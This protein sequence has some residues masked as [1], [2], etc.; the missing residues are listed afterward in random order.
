MKLFLKRKLEESQAAA[1]TCRTNTPCYV[2]PLYTPVNS[3][4]RKRKK[5]K[6]YIIKPSS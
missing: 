5:R 1:V 3:L 6:K 2:V 4:R